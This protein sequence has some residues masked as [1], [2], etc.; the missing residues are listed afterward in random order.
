MA[1]RK[2]VHSARNPRRA[3]FGTGTRA[4]GPRAHARQGVTYAEI[5]LRPAAKWQGGEGGL[6]G[7]AKAFY[8]KRDGQKYIVRTALRCAAHSW[9]GFRPTL[10]S[11]APRELQGLS[12]L[13]G[14]SVKAVSFSGMSTAFLMSA[15]S[16]AREAALPLYSLLFF[17]S[18]RRS[19]SSGI[20]ARI[21]LVA[22][23]TATLQHCNTATLQHWNGEC[24]T[25][26][27]RTI[28]LGIGWVGKKK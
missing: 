20:A 13:S 3:N 23:N 21:A 6:Q 11:P 27:A 14:L 19:R 2:K 22:C 24:Q 28:Y 5:F 25:S 10:S 8:F 1:A 17:S 15:A 9:R 4:V 18:G 12:G 16:L 7:S 26:C